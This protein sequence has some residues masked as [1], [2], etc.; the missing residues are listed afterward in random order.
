[1]IQVMTKHR[2]IWH[3]FTTSHH[4]R[5]VMYYNLAECLKQI[6]PPKI[7]CIYIYKLGA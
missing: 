7:V 3:S 1:M 4:L 2:K 6:R 5:Q